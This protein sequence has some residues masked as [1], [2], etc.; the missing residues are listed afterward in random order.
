MDARLGSEL[1]AAVR[2]YLVR[3][4]L[5]VHTRVPRIEYADVF[6]VDDLEEAVA[7]LGTAMFSRH[8]YFDDAA[9]RI[10]LG[11]ATGIFVQFGNFGNHR[12]FCKD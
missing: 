12:V 7:A 3:Y 8:P 10:H 4:S 1:V 11:Q 2:S 6:I 5:V 9:Y